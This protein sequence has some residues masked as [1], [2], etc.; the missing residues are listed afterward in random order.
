MSLIAVCPVIPKEEI[1]LSMIMIKNK[2]EK[3]KIL[4]SNPMILHYGKRAHTYRVCCGKMETDK[5][6]D[7][8]LLYYSTEFEKM[9]KLLGTCLRK[10]S[11][12]SLEV[13]VVY[14]G[15]CQVAYNEL[16]EVMKNV[17]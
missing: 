15:D 7:Q 5:L 2:I 16:K 4:N 9:D 11:E 8:Y 17:K 3:Y 14:S 10:Q 1:E 12:S 6:F 13:G